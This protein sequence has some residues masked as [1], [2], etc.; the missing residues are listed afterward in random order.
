MKISSPNGIFLIYKTFSIVACYFN[1][2][3]GKDIGLGN[4]LQASKPKLDY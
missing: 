3:K 1:K 2:R 4:Y